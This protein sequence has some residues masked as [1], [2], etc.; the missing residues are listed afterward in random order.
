MTVRVLALESNVTTLE[1]H[2]LELTTF[3]YPSG[4]LTGESGIRP[5]GAALSSDT[6]MVAT[7]APF[8]A[9]IQGSSATQGGY[10]FVSDD[11]VDITFDAGEAGNARVDRVIARVYDDT[12]DASG[13][14]QGAVEYLKG[15]SGGSASTVPANSILLWEISVPAG[16]SAGG[17]PINFAN[18]VDKRP[19]TSANGGTLPVAT[20]TIRDAL[21]N[22]YD[23][24]VIYRQDRDWVEI[25]NGTSWKVMNV[26]KVASFANL[27]L[28]TSPTTGDLAVT[29]D[30]KNLYQYSGSAWVLFVE[31]PTAPRPGQ[32]IFRGRCTTAVAFTSASP[33]DIPWNVE[34]WDTFGIHSTSSNNSRLRPTV[35]GLYT[36][37][38]A[39]GFEGSASGTRTIYWKK[40]GNTD[41]GTQT[42]YG[43]AGAV[44]AI[45]PART[46]TY[47]MNGTTDYVQ[48]VGQTNG[49][50]L[51]LITT[52]N[53]AQ[54]SVEVFYSGPLP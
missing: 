36:F 28:I 3:Q 6:N 11:D 49:V 7:I 47:Q 27:S 45:L 18:A 21:T 48:L 53:Q 13:F 31:A 2:R 19:F 4:E 17:T 1:D 23:G 9:W 25:H 33:E 14:V 29:S 8:T 32:C 22:T 51:D 34:D 5:G 38:G 24:K 30:T 54:S 20:A 16:A 41:L 12:Y 10:P 42:Q 26:P 44:S 39:L 46:V 40:N 35:A 37:Q 43:P 52:A 15:Q 50:S